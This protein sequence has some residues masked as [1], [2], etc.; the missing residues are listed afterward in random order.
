[1]QGVVTLKK[2]LPIYVFFISILFSPFQLSF[3]VANE[4][5]IDYHAV[6][7]P[8]YNESGNLQI[9]IRMYE[10]NS[11]TYF[12]TVD[13]YTLA[14]KELQASAFK[15][16]GIS[17]DQ[18]PGYITMDNLKKTPYL[19]A[20]DSYTSSPYRLQNQ[21][22]VQADHPVSGMFLTI[23]MCPASK[24]FEAS[25]FKN[26]ASLS[27]KT[28]KPVPIALSMSGLWMLT[29]PEEFSWLIEQ[30]KTNKLAITWINH[31]FSHVYYRDLPL[32]DNFM[33]NRPQD[34]T[35][36][37]L[38]E[39]KELLGH[40]KMPSVFFRFPGLVSNQTLI[41]IL[42]ELGLIPV[43]A[44]AWLAKGEIPKNGSVILV[45]GNS[46]EP[47]GIKII[48]PLLEDPELNLL[49]LHQAILP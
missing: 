32:E 24:P 21:G 40:G 16:R 13:P 44:N 37:V 20:L 11:T 29:H 9:A 3:A 5:I 15:V 14:T 34:F 26:L 1:M 12:L 18:N 42:R 48:T 30:E 49:P 33:L 22:L 27:D 8:G 19:K 38:G 41:I 28:K 10:K 46:N 43:G 6:F 35:Q 25:F 23:D 31:S 47:K 2:K 45:H 17:N 7:F 36:E 4:S 39:E